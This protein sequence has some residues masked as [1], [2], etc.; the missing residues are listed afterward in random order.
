[1]DID[2]SMRVMLMK[3]DIYQK[4]LL[5]NIHLIEFCLLFAY[6]L[7]SQIQDE[8]LN[9]GIILEGTLLFAPCIGL[10]ISHENGNINSIFHSDKISTE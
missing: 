9:N 2:I 5:C 4:Y 7:N 10:E 1:M 3:N 6:R 8:A